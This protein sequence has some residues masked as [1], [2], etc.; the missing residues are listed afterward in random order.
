MYYIEPDQRSI[1]YIL[2]YMDISLNQKIITEFKNIL[3]DD[4]TDVNYEFDE[5]GFN[6]SFEVHE[7]FGKSNYETITKFLENN[8]FIYHYPW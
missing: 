4:L 7:T 8:G 2:N 1:I 3:W 6:Y 5:N